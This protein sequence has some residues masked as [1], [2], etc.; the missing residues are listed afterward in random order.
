MLSNTSHLEQPETEEG[1]EIPERVYLNF[2]STSTFMGILSTIRN[3]HPE[4]LMEFLS[5]LPGNGPYIE[6][7]NSKVK[8]AQSKIKLDLLEINE[9]NIY[10]KDEQRELLDQILSKA[11]LRGVAISIEQFTKLTE[12]IVGDTTE[13][14]IIR[15]SY[16]QGYLAEQQRDKLKVLKHHLNLNSAS[17]NF[18]NDGSIVAR[19]ADQIQELIDNI[20][21]YSPDSIQSIG[22]YIYRAVT[23]SEWRE[24]QNNNGRFL[25]LVRTNFEN[26]QMFEGENSQVRLFANKN[27]SG[28][29]NYS[30]KVIRIDIS[31]TPFF[32]ISGMQVLR[33]ESTIPHF[34]RINGY[35][36]SSEL[37][38]ETINWQEFSN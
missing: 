8:L 20:R 9:K 3:A 6:I 7:D 13:D 30:G 24:I 11:K 27:D 4:G 32:A 17:I 28:A 21:S 25:V 10:L 12:A 1:F 5:T 26:G 36:D 33:V 18:V 14:E 38:N 29:E 37:N 2:S 31:N 23:E 19:G 16:V 22:Q 15:L 35:I 34:T